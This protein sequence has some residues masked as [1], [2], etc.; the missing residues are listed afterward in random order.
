[1]FQNA[2]QI[3]DT[4]DRWYAAAKLQ[5]L[6][7][8]TKHSDHFE[9]RILGPLNWSIICAASAKNFALVFISNHIAHH[10]QAVTCPV[11]SED[12]VVKVQDYSLWK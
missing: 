10:Y 11:G 4:S 5:R 1:M 9:L 6:H 8:E 3:F 12:G 7:T 2:C